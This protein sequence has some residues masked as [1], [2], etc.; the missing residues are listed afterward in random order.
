MTF[1]GC[2]VIVRAR[3]PPTGKAVLQPIKAISSDTGN[4][5][6]CVIGWREW[7]ALPDLGISRLKCKTDTGA[8]SSALHAYFVE[9]FHEGGKE[10]VRFG[11]HPRQ[12]STKRAVVCTADVLDR[13]EEARVPNKTIKTGIEQVGT[14][15]VRDGRR[16]MVSSW[17][18]C[19]VVRVDAR[20]LT[21]CNGCPIAGRTSPVTTSETTACGAV[22]SFVP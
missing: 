8:R 5:A 10:L 13:L 1:V 16:C 14:S 15:T 19:Q 17:W 11:L 2:V 7:V 20:Q 4:S 18:L 22:D 3:R 9:T 6:L 21:G 12:K